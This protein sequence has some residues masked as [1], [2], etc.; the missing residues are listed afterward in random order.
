MIKARGLRHINLNVRDVG[1]S[2]KFY[3]DAFGLEV[4]FWE[5]KKMVFVSSPGAD[6]TIR[7]CQA[8]EGDPIA[9]GGVSHFGFSIGKNNL[10]EMI[11][12]ILKAGGKLQSRGQHAPGVPYAYF[13]DL[14]GYV[15]ELGNS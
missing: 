14:D 13:T 5:G 15:I 10:D 4:K 9:G 7:L 6:E 3:Q 1:R 8:R 11:G 12:Q 2:L